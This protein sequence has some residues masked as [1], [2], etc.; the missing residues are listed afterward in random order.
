LPPKSPGGAEVELAHR[1]RGQ[2]LVGDLFLVQ[3]LLQ[4]AGDIGTA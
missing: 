3:R 2:H 1:Q 4:E